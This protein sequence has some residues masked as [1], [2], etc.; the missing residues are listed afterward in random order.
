MMPNLP[1]ST[2]NTDLEMFSRLFQEESYQPD[3]LKIYPLLILKGAPLYAQWA[4]GDVPIYSEEELVTLIAKICTQLPP[5][6]RIQRIQ[7]DIPVPLIVAGPKKSNLTQYVDEAL[8]QEGEVCNCIRCREV[9][10]RSR[11]LSYD[12]LSQL[13]PK[14]LEHHYPASNGTEIF[15]SYEDPKENVLI[16]FIRARIPSDLPVS[17]PILNHT[18]NYGFIRELHVYGKTI[19]VGGHDKYEWQHQGYGKR[20]LAAAEKI[21]RERYGIKHMFVTSGIGVREYY[22]NLGY[23][24]QA[25]YM[26]KPL[27]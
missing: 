10:I 13:Q 5:W 8:K 21:C 22:Q 11:D 12:I 23:S 17:I 25:P 27:D 15:L 6:V 7:R 14:L 3:M 4:A 26:G 16:G 9:G 24:L 20:L 1:G 19:P 18:S 2:W